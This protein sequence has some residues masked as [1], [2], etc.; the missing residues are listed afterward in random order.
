MYTFSA[1]A[2]LFS[3]FFE[4]QTAKALQVRRNLGAGSCHVLTEAKC[5]TTITLF[6]EGRDFTKFARVGVALML[7][8]LLRNK[9]QRNKV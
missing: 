1:G 2:S 3:L 7:N 5:R 6:A 4:H 9:S 8:C